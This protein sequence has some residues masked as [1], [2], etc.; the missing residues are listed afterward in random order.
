VKDEDQATQDLSRRHL[1]VGWWCLLLYLLLGMAL[2]A[3]HGFK[4]GS[5]L[6]VGNEPRRLMWRLAHAHGTLLA[7][8]NIA[9]GLTMRSAPETASGLA[10]GCLLAALL[11]IPVGFF[12]GGVVI[13]GGDPGAAILIVP[14]GAAALAIGVALV[15]RALR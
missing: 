1:R 13:H 5:Y 2:E 3:L 9:Y 10:S 11:F 7:L 15:A 8:V 12:A 4:A 6:D 14:P